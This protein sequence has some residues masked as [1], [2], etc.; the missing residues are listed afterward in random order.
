MNRPFKL[1]PKT[2]NRVGMNVALDILSFAVLNGFME[3]PDRSDLVVAVGFVRG[4]DGVRRYYSLNERHQRNHLDVLNSA[5]LDLAL[6]LNRTKHGSLTSGTTSTLATANA[7]NLGFVQ[8]NN[9]LPIQRI[10]RLFHEYADL[11]VDSPGTLISN[12]KVPFKFLSSNPILALANQENGVEPH[13]KRSRAFVENCSLG[14]VSLEAASASVGSAVGNWMECRLAALRAF[15][16]FW[17][18]LLKDMRQA[19]IVVGEVLLKSLMVY[20]MSKGYQNGHLL[21]RDSCL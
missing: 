2:L 7:A 11:L 6:P 17:I 19:S 10:R 16:T 18:T 15:Q 4:D 1:R 5:S 8:L 20:L 13:S 21:S 12:A 14:R 9:L 3:M